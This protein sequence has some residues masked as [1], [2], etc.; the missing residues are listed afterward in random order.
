MIKILK[1]ITITILVVLI[2][3]GISIW[4]PWKYLLN[5]ALIGQNSALTVNSVSGKSEVFLDDKKIGE[6]PLSLDNLSSGDFTIEMKRITSNE[7]F[8][9]TISKEIHIEPNTR[10]LV[11]VEIGPSDQFCS[12]SIIYYRDNNSPGSSMYLNS[13]PSNSTITM[14]ETEY[15]DSPVVI[16]DTESGEHT[17]TVEAIGYETLDVSVIS[18]DGYTLIAEFDLMIKPIVIE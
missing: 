16:D 6:T 17:I 5:L 12:T 8:Y 11:E 10:T 1:K 15:T 18:R 2:V 9:T 13:I 7:S 4:Q 14:D 3:V